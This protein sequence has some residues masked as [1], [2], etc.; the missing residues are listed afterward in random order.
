MYILEVTIQKLPVAKHYAL[1]TPWHLS[2]T[3][4]PN[5][6]GIT[7]PVTLVTPWQQNMI[8]VGNLSV[9]QHFVV[10]LSG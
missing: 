8:C 1:A 4:C 9:W 6:D 10:V 2:V 7:G 5:N 3:W